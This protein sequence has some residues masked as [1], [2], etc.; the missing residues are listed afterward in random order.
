[1]TVFPPCGA[2][3]CGSPDDVRAKRG[4]V[5]AARGG[6]DTGCGAGGDGTSAVEFTRSV[7]WECLDD[8][9]PPTVEKIGTAVVACGPKDASFPSGIGKSPTG[10][11]LEP[12]VDISWAFPEKLV[13]AGAAWVRAD[14]NDKTFAYSSI[15]SQNCLHKPHSAMGGSPCF[16]HGCG[17]LKL[18][19]LPTEC[20]RLSWMG[21]RLQQLY[22]C[23]K[24]CHSNVEMVQ[25]GFRPIP[26]ACPEQK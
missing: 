6:L 8:V 10:D 19:E 7:C 22:G 25:R 20:E 5:G 18:E 12:I 4:T 26:A 24:A 16:G 1:M 21:G 23:D 2:G 15:A 13:L 17:L 14:C 11:D 3:G 9:S